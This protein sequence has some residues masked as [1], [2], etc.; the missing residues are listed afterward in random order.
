MATGSHR[1]VNEKEESCVFCT[2][3]WFRSAELVFRTD[4]CIY[5]STRDPRD[6]EEVLPGCGVIVPVVHRP[7]AFHLTPE[8]WADTRELQIKVRTATS[9]WRQTAMCSAGTTFLDKASALRTPTSTSSRA[10]TT[11]HFGTVGSG[12]RSRCPR[13][14]GRTLCGRAMAARFSD[15]IA[16][17]PLRGC[18]G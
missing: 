15:E 5:A 2:S 4:L 10:S 6:P 14:F 13:T 3:D 16:E 8:E 9:A 11:S 18:P 12:R 7:S 1:A 17:V